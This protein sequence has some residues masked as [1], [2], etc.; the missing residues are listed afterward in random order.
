VRVFVDVAD[1]AENRTFFVDF[2]NQ[3]KTRFQQLDVWMTTYL[4]EIL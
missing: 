2:K 3:L 4:V 1:T